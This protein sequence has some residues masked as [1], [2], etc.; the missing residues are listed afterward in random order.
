[1]L[2]S[3][4]DTKERYNKFL[5]M[6]SVSALFSQLKE[7]KRKH[8]IPSMIEFEY[9]ENLSML[10]TTQ[11]SLYI[12]DEADWLTRTITVNFNSRY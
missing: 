12:L 5:V 6:T 10:D 4:D 8:K 11:A 9:S 7:I 3:S 1:M 2:S